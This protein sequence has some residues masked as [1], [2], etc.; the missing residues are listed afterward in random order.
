MHGMAVFS[1]DIQKEM[2]DTSEKVSSCKGN[3]ESYPIA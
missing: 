2:K 1:E 3:K